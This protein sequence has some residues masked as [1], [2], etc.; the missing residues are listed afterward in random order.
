MSGG[1]FNYVQH[2]IRDIYE[3]IE[4]EINKMGTLKSKDELKYYSDDW[5]DKYPEDKYYHKYSE[6]VIN[7]FKNAVYVL[8]KAYIYAH[9]IDW[10]LSGDDGEDSFLKRLHEEL[11][12]LEYEKSK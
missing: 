9:R 4:N 5:F 10:L 6:E 12:K 7:E 11:N 8:K 1:A 3:D 2:K